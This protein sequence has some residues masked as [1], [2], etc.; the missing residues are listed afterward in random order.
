MKR[1]FCMSLATVCLAFASVTAPARGAEF[2]NPGPMTEKS[3][4]ISEAVRVGPFVFLSGKLGTLPG[5]STLA[6]GGIKAEARQAME[7]IAA[8]LGRNGLSFKN[9]IKCTVFL[10]DASELAQ[11]N[12]V[13]KT[14][15][16]DFNYPTRSAVGVAGL[17][18]NA[19]VE[20]EC[21]AEAAH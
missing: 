3:Y 21:L 12:E 6:S 7:N 13:Y 20:V 17:A 2:L 8:V 5:T 16:P 11:F 15:F 4:P 14:Y 10:A 1:A 19:R 18:L 9:V